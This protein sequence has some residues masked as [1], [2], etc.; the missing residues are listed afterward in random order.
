MAKSDPRPSDKVAAKFDMASNRADLR[1]SES[2]NSGH[3]LESHYKT[4][5]SQATDR[6]KFLG[7]PSHKP[8]VIPPE[9]S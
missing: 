2:K 9:S 7:A 3:S 5:L 8:V 1:P 4:T 6:P